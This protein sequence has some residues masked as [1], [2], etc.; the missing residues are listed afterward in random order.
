MIKYLKYYGLPVLYSVISVVSDSS[1]SDDC[2]PQG[3]SVHVD[4]PGKNTGVGCLA[5]LQGIFPTQGSSPHLFCLLHWQV[6]SLPPAPPGKPMMV[7]LFLCEDNHFIRHFCTPHY[8]IVF[9]RTSLLHLYPSFTCN[10]D[11]PVSLEIFY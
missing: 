2:S 9:A 4:S 6:G 5:L 8:P 7:F 1:W 10:T 3:S 11:G